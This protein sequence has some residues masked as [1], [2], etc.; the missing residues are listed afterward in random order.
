MSSFAERARRG[1]ERCTDDDLAELREF[2]AGIYGDRVDEVATASPE[3]LFDANPFRSPE[4]RGLWICR[5]DGRIVGQQAEV[6]FGLR[7][8][9]ETLRVS[10]AIELMV[11][12]AWR[13]RGVGPALSQV[14]LDASRVVVGLSLSA[15]GYRLYQRAGWIDLGVIDRYVMV[16]RNVAEHGNPATGARDRAVA[17]A[18][19]TAAVGA[20]SLA[21]A[22]TAST[23]LEAIDAFDA[24][25]DGLW[26]A[27]APSYPVLA[28]RDV[29]SLRWRLDLSPNADSYRRFYVLRRDRVVG[30]FVVR[31]SRWRGAP[32]L[33]V[34]DYFADPRWVGVVLAH[35][36]TLAKREGNALVQV[37]TRNRPAHRR[38]QSLGF[39]RSERRN[40]V[41]FMIWI[42]ADD[43]LHDVLTVPD[44]WLITD[45]DADRQFA[46]TAS[47]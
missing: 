30:Y 13:L 17:V 24:R 9:G 37:L 36:V 2:R 3:W 38:I 33:Q 44:N 6:A 22:R 39:V 42:D 19:A 12:P 5:R 26:A 31:S 20:V 47:G 7:A 4:G 35:C 32:M 29:E 8:S 16:L 25:A 34:V 43:P 11:D 18:T 15:D 14:Q 45:A 40:P 23:H 21:H 46:A 10:A 41:R 1:I 27:V 28:C